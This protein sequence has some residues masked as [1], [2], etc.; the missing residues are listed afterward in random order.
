MATKKTAQAAKK[1]S[2]SSN[3]ASA[4]AGAATDPKRAALVIQYYEGQIEKLSQV[5]ADLAGAILSL[6]PETEAADLK[7]FNESLAKQGIDLELQAPKKTSKK[8][9]KKGGKKA[10]KKA[11]KSGGKKVAKKGNKKVAKN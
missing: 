3:K 8:A 5:V 7:A 2:K 4:A 11:A 9:A 6:D 10:A 1:A